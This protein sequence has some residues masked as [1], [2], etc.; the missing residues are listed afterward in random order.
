M[1]SAHSF[2]RYSLYALLTPRQ[3]I[4]PFPSQSNLHAYSSLISSARSI[5]RAGPSEL[6]RGFL[7]S[8][9]RDAPY[10]GLFL[11]FYEG[12]K[13]EAASILP[14]SSP[15]TSAML[16]S[17]SGAAAGTVATLATHPFD[18]IKVLH[19]FFSFFRALTAP[20]RP[21]CKFEQ[22]KNIMAS[23]EQSWLCG[24][25]VPLFDRLSKH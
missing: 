13:H 1:K 5:T 20:N 22:N 14:P 19:F 17:C 21:E 2:P 7:A 18:V 24:T 16:H 15:L 10:A 4:S 11:V 23:P 25:S 8:S 6:F 12:I 3:K 9:L